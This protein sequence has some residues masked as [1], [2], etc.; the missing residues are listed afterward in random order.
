M[1]SEA[2]QIGNA[3]ALTSESSFED[4]IYGSNIF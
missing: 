3:L 4:F 1:L 2:L